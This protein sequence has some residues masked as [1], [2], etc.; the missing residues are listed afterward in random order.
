MTDAEQEQLETKHGLSWWNTHVHTHD[1][2][3]WTDLLVPDRSSFRA[4]F[5]LFPSAGPMRV[6][7]VE[8]QIVYGN[9]GERSERL[10]SVLSETYLKKYVLTRCVLFG[11][12]KDG[13]DD[14]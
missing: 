12:N 11:I 8:W 4:A 7:R 2:Y 6:E 1:T 10:P 5:R 14:D 3:A 9:R 13:D